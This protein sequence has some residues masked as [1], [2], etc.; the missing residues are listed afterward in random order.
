ME[1]KILKYCTIFFSKLL[2]EIETLEII[3]EDNFFYHIKLQS[4]DWTLLIWQN[5]ETIESLQ[6]VLWMSI[7][8]IFDKKIK[9]KLEINNYYKSFEDKLFWRIDRNIT[10]LIN[11]WWE[12]ELWIL[13]PYNRKRIHSYIA[14]KY[15]NIISKS[16]WKWENRRMY[17]YISST[18]KQE[19]KSFNTNN[20]SKKLTIDINWNWI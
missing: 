13:S 3:K 5:W 11:N 18:G 16:K 19:K 4:T 14:K 8:N 7:I 10:S 15:D 17:L 20:I 6:K 9:I 1:N 12:Y 2:I